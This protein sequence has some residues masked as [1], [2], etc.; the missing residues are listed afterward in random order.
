MGS[1]TAV[2]VYDFGMFTYAMKFLPSDRFKRILSIKDVKTTEFDS[3]VI[4]GKRVTM[5]SMEDV[6]EA[7]KLLKANQPELFKK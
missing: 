5:K 7:Y 3:V 1:L 2:F 6:S 4:V